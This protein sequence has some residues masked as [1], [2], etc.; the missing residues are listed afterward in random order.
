MQGVGGRPAV[1]RTK[2][3][4]LVRKELGSFGWLSLGSSGTSGDVWVWDWGLPCPK[5]G[6]GAWLEEADPGQAIP[7]MPPVPTVLSTASVSSLEWSLAREDEMGR[8]SQAGSTAVLKRPQRFSE[9]T[10]L[11]IPR[12]CQGV[13]ARTDSTGRGRRSWEAR[14]QRSLQPCGKQSAHSAPTQCPGSISGPCQAPKGLPGGSSQMPGWCHQES[15]CRKECVLPARSG[16]VSP[17]QCPLRLALKKE[18]FAEHTGAWLLVGGTA[19]AF[20]AQ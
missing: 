5:L 13:W 12:D 17:R 15:R 10:L 2:K 3:E 18:E 1:W 8:L 19:R 14:P 9:G 6:W 16:T 20:S 4:K 11:H 7:C